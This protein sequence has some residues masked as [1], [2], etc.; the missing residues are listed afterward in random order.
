MERG[1]IEGIH[2]GGRQGSEGRYIVNG[3]MNLPRRL[4]FDNYRIH[5]KHQE[6]YSIYKKEDLSKGYKR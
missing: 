1:E 4:Y 6:E 2:Q 3:G 5:Q